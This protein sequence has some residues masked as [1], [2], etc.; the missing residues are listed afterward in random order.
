MKRSTSNI[1]LCNFFPDIEVWPDVSE[2]TLT[3]GE[4]RT[5]TCKGNIPVQW[6]FNQ[7]DQI[8]PVQ[9]VNTIGFS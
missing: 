7:Y 4:N 5:F 8:S 2:L 9:K 1:R 3:S 6:Y